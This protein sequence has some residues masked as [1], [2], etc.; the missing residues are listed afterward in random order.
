M[1][2]LFAFCEKVVV[3]SLDQGKAVLFPDH[4]FRKTLDAVCHSP[5]QGYVDKIDEPKD[6]KTSVWT[7]YVPQGMEQ[8]LVLFSI[9]MN[10]E[11]DGVHPQQVCK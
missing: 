9:V 4:G 7:I 8:R 5:N 1:L 11:W 3:V 6:G 2:K 10:P